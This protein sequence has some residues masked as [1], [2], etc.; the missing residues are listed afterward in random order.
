M[1]RI[2]REIDFSGGRTVGARQASPQPGGQWV[3]MFFMRFDEASCLISITP[4]ATRTRDLLP[5]IR[6]DRSYMSV[7]I[8]FARPGEL[9]FL[10]LPV[11]EAPNLSFST[12]SAREESSQSDKASSMLAHRG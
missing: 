10:P 8:A 9:R 5:K 12:T 11:T 3:T 1:E 6:V 4:A 2:F 7:R